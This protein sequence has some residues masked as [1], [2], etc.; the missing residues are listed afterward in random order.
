MRAF[1]YHS[2]VLSFALHLPVVMPTVLSFKE[3]LL[4]AKISNF[5][6]EKVLTWFVPLRVKSS[7]QMLFLQPS[8]F[9][10]HEEFCR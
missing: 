6:R 1:L 9:L 7:P 10:P 8:S 3:A 5:L 2:R 4:F